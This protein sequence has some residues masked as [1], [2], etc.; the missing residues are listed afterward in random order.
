VHPDGYLLDRGFQVFL[1]EYP[2]AKALFDG[3]DLSAL[4][5]KQFLPGAKVYY[6]GEFHLVS[7]PFRRPQDIIA[8][9]ISPIGSLL[10]KVKVGIFS[11]LV[12][13]LSVEQLLARKEVSTL[14]FL[15]DS[16]GDTGGLG[17]DREMIERFFYPF[18]QGIFLAPLATQSS[19]MF[20]FVFKMFSEGAA[21]LPEKGMGQ[22]G[23]VLAEKLPSGSVR[24]R[25]RVESLS[26]T[27]T[28]T[29]EVVVH[30]VD[31]DTREIVECKSV[32]LAA[33]PESS[34]TLVAESAGLVWGSSGSNRAGALAI[35][36]PR[37]S[38]CLYFGFDGPPPV[39]EP[40]LIL[41]GESK[42]A[43][44][45]SAREGAADDEGESLPLI[46]NVCFPSQVSSAYA[47]KGQSLASVTIVPQPA[48]DADTFSDAEL[49]RCVRRQLG[50]WFNEKRDDNGSGSSS[51]GDDGSMIDKW[52]LLRIYRIAYAQPAQ[53][54]LPYQRDI[55]VVLGSNL[56]V[57]GDHRG[58]ATLNG[59][60]NSGKRAA[61]KVLELDL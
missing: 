37:R 6:D 34:K 13:F 32:V 25:N 40:M 7:D 36:A 24:Y 14:E 11:V 51:P 5:L 41:N 44:G 50:E 46:N 2:E 28:G 20:Q 8:S 45:A 33:D 59:A 53:Y 61:S 1:E 10:D 58:T 52:T 43:V 19:L 18:Y 49:E 39:L 35:P 26:R 21:S 17:L 42:L 47:P 22:I 12:R 9:L 56:F 57:C 54:P 15:N 31:D 38:I 55:D 48:D 30:K 4:N 60:I 3:G 16:N 27:P 29:I 23:A